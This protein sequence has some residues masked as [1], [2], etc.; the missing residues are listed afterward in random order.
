MVEVEAQFEVEVKSIIIY[1]THWLFTFFI[2]KKYSTN[3]T[4]WFVYV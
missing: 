4:A 1:W 3:T 2:K